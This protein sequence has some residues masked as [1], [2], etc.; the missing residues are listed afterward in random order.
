MPARTSTVLLELRQLRFGIVAGQESVDSVIIF[1]NRKESPELS[2][3]L[4]H[5][6]ISALRG[7]GAL[8]LR[9]FAFCV[10]GVLRALPVKRHG[11]SGA[12]DV[13]ATSWGAG[14][15]F[16]RQCAV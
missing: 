5:D 1:S 3:I 7:F 11:A 4:S 14:Y 15:N 9:S 16:L 13:L 2:L 10:C 6:G 8:R 12:F